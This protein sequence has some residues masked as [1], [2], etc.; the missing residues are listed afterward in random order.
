MPPSLTALHDSHTYVLFCFYIT[1]IVIVIVLL[2]HYYFCIKALCL[3][4]DVDWGAYVVYSGIRLRIGKGN[5]DGF[6]KNI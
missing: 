5:P 6:S 2:C 4:G 3:Q 1:V